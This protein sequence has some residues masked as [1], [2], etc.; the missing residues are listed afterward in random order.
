MVTNRIEMPLDDEYVVMLILKFNEIRENGP[1]VQRLYDSI[2]E[3]IRAFPHHV[4]NIPKGNF[5]EILSQSRQIRNFVVSF[6]FG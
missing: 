6:R 4:Q 5:C 3:Y 1:D 2:I